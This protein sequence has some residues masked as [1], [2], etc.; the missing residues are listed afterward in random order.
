LKLSVLALLLAP[1]VSGNKQLFCWSSWSLFCFKNNAFNCVYRIKL[2]AVFD[3]NKFPIIPI[4]SKRIY[5]Q[6]YIGI[7][8]IIGKLSISKIGFNFIYFIY[9][10]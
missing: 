2:D 8:Q 10:I 9:F 3:I 7:F 5:R 4:L 6:R 1:K